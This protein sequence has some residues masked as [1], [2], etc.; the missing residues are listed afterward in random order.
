M[1]AGVCRRPGR[2]GSRATGRRPSLC[3]C[4]RPANARSCNSLTAIVVDRSSQYFRGGLPNSAGYRPN[5]GLTSVPLYFAEAVVLV[6]VFYPTLLLHPFAVT[7][8]FILG[9]G[10]FYAIIPG[11][12][13][14]GPLLF[15]PM[16]RWEA[17]SPQPNA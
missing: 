7:V 5:P 17:G 9:A 14:V 16:K 8:G 11:L 13:I 6:I 15:E 12:K 4:N 10:F 1:M 3:G 2:K